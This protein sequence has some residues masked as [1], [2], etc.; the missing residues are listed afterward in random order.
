MEQSS[1]ER[2]CKGSEDFDDVQ[3]GQPVLGRRRSSSVCAQVSMRC[4]HATAR[5]GSRSAPRSGSRL[6]LWSL[7]RPSARQAA[8]EA[9]QGAGAWE[10][11]WRDSTQQ[12]HTISEL[13]LVHTHM[14]IASTPASVTV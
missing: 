12:A 1:A 9:N 13:A 2:R 7:A 5:G 11:A 14:Y 10:G 6:A 3:I 4:K 8:P